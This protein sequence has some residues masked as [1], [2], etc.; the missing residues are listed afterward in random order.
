MTRARLLNLVGIAIGIA[1]VAFVVVRIIRDRHD[2]ADALA[3]ADPVWLVVAFL[4]GLCAMSLIG[5]NWLWIM[6]AAGAHTT[7]RRGMSW[8][9]V[10][11]L[12]KYVPGGIWPIVGQA[13]LAHRGATPRPVA[14]TSTAISMAATFLGAAVVGA[15]TGLYA[16]D[17]QRWIAAALAG[18][19]VVAFGIYLVPSA[20]AALAT[21]AGRIARRPV[22]LPAPP[23][24][25]TLIGRHLPVWF[26]F[27]GMSIFTVAALDTPL[28]ARLV[29]RL[30]AV[31]CLS[32]MAGFVI[33]GL[34]GG[35]GV[36]ETVFISMMTAPLGAGTA[37]SVAVVSR[38]VSV[39]VDLLGA[40]MS[41]PFAR[42]ASTP[43]TAPIDADHDDP[44]RYAA[45]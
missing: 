28:D 34:P 7:L 42:T 30:I 3:A 1:G 36:R 6:S 25:A 35:I 45:P 19:L 27:S 15:A 13:E 12:G 43:A 9:F 18:G 26:F 37:V 33:I 38:A 11:Q 2:I 22:R 32:W 44:N 23:W 29:F 40:A 16:L 14:Y 8:Y 24:I 10:G 20:R 39:A 5:V 4:S 31:T 17:D 21:L 41:V